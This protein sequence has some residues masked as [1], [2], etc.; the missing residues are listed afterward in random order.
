MTGYLNGNRDKI[1]VE[2][3]YTV[4]FEMG[5]LVLFYRM[6]H[7][8]RIGLEMESFFGMQSGHI[9]SIFFDASICLNSKAFP[10]CSL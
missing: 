8:T 10:H 9:A 4:P 3:H 6:A 2:Q 5:M 7:T 1:V